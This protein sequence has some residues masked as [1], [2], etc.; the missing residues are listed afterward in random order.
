MAVRGVEESDARNAR[1]LEMEMLNP[2]FALPFQ[3]ARLGWEAHN[4]MTLCWIRL[5]GGGASSQS[6]AHRMATEKAVAFVEAHTAATTVAIKG[7][8]RHDAAKKVLAVHKKR[9]GRNKRRL[10]K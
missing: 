10:S 2:W 3:A 1:L 5:A 9:V 7:G 8:H 4:V 6:E